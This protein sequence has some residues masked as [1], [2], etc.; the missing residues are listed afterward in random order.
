MSPYREGVQSKLVKQIEGITLGW[1]IALLPPRAYMWTRWSCGGIW[2]RPNDSKNIHSTLPTKLQ[3]WWDDTYSLVLP[4][5]RAVG[6]L[7]VKLT[8]LNELNDIIYEVTNSTTPVHRGLTAPIPPVTFEE[9]RIYVWN[10]RGVG[11]ASF[12][13]KVFTMT[14]MMRSIVVVLKDTSASN[15]NAW[16]LLNKAHNVRYYYKE[17]LGF[18]GKVAILWDNTRGVVS[19]F[20]NHNMD[21]SF[22]IE[23]HILLHH[24]MVNK[25][26]YKCETVQLTYDDNLVD[27]VA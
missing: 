8:T 15:R 10:Y 2:H 26:C 19:G 20:T 6:T 21:I 9:V 7:N 11:I 23:V 3:Q 24:Q 13:P 1:W 18:V 16:S 17:L 4:S 25:S 22:I 12:W 27:F 5:D 14:S